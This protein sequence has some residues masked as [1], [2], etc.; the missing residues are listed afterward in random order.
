VTVL[1]QFPGSAEVRIL[2]DSVQ[3]QIQ[4]TLGRCTSLRDVNLKR[5]VTGPDCPVVEPPPPETDSISTTVSL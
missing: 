5:N 1:A 2:A 4:G 3:S